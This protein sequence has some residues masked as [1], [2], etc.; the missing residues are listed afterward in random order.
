MRFKFQ[1]GLST[2]LVICTLSAVGLKVYKRWEQRPSAA[3]ERLKDMQA[4]VQHFEL[5]DA[6][7]IGYKID[8]GTAWRG[9]DEGLR[10]ITYLDN[11]REIRIHQWSHICIDSSCAREHCRRKYFQ[12]VRARRQLPIA[13][14]A[15]FTKSAALPR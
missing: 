1:Y 11:V 14:F 10:N 6:D 4:E 9:G 12:L 8:I 13:G 7:Y 3:L 5:G 15:S 2:L